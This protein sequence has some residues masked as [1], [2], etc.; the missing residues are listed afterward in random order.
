MGLYVGVYFVLQ[1]RHI[2]STILADQHSRRHV[3]SP[4]DQMAHGQGKAK[5]GV[6]L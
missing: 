6:I 3:C 5:N 2:H 4:I 1:I